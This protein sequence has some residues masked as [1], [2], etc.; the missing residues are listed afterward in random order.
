LE[1]E[2]DAEDQAAL[3]GTALVM[4]QT[5]GFEEVHELVLGRCSMCH[6]REPFWDGIRRA[7]KGI[8]LETEADV[9][10][11][12]DAIYLHA[13]VTDAMPPANVTFM[14]PEDRAAIRRWFRAAQM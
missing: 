13:G 14:E 11:Q 6:A 7:P 2:G 4:A 10:R 9:A 5:E 12:A 8:L 3:R 1:T